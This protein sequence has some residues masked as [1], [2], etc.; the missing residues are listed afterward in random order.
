MQPESAARLLRAIGHSLA[1][2]GLAF[3][4]RIYVFIYSDNSLVF[5]FLVVV[6]VTYSSS[7]FCLA[8]KHWMHC[9]TIAI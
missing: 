9:G 6:I 8:D 1:G 3:V 4:V 2:A 5:V 7:F